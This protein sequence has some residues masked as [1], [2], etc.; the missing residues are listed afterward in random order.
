MRV[1]VKARNRSYEFESL[2][3]EK[4]LFAGL[5]NEIELPY[6]CASGTCGTCKAKLLDGQIADPWPHA[7][8]R[9]YLKADHGEFLMCQCAPQS[10]IRV[11][12]AS[13]VNPMSARA[14]PPRAF[15]G[16]I[17][18]RGMLTHDVMALEVALDQPCDFD[19]G[20]FVALE[21]ADVPG[22]RGYSMVNFER[23]ARV[24]AFVV[25]KKPDGGVSEWLFRGDRTGAP[26]RAFGPLGRATFFPGVEKN[27]LCIAGG[28]GIAGMMSI[29]SHACQEKHFGRYHGYLFFGV[30][31]MQDAFY[32]TELRE[33]AQQYPDRLHITVALSDEDVPVDAASRHP[34]LHF[35]RGLVHEVVARE[36][37]GR[38]DNVRAYVA[39]PPPC[40]DA[41]IRMLLLEGK[42]STDNVRYDKF[43]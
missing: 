10:D 22:Y 28:S 13:F 35:A 30:R 38:F 2:P 20:Q 12:I 16:T 29:V 24:L 9:R 36:M 39:G 37:R 34:G 31:T 42:L 26:V 14:C 25:K 15:N 1:Q 3:G 6:E 27:L 23:L 8:G 40:V 32:L 5:R 11:E 18:K 7:P 19:A 43:S 4:L 33:L 21:V 17:R 41:A